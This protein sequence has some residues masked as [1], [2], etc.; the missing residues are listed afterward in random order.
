MIDKPGFPFGPAHRQKGLTL[1]ELTTGLIAIGLV[2]GVVFVSQ[3]LVK[4][5]TLRGQ[6]KQINMLE[7]Q[8]TTF[9]IKYDCLPGDCSNITG[10]LGN[11][12]KTGHDI[13]NGDGNNF[14]QANMPPQP[15]LDDN[16]KPVAATALDCLSGTLTG[17]PTQMYLQINA[18]GL[19]NYDRADDPEY[20]IRNGI[21]SAAAN[22]QTG[23]VVNCTLTGGKQ[24]NAI[25][26][27]IASSH[28]MLIG[29]EY[30]TPGLRPH[31]S[32]AT[33]T[34]MMDSGHW[35]PAFNQNGPAG[36]PV[37]VAALLD[38]KIDDGQPDSGNFGIW[39]TIAQSPG[40]CIFTPPYTSYKNMGS[41]CNAVLASKV[42][43]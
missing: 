4:A 3:T 35:N 30:N 42:G 5:A 40:H 34:G 38:A 13:V 29:V 11:K 36:I 19:A 18:A 16:T 26:A 28:A 17:E 12:D 32:L 43:F 24:G 27:F 10:L 41:S 39:M 22:R 15:P 1:I 8:L 23:M 2:I 6:I 7:E 20:Y 9:R 21:P 37:S 14:I 33:D 31:D 25:P